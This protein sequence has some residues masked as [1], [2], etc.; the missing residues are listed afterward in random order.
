[1]ALKEDPSPSS[2]LFNS[3]PSSRQ[4]YS[5]IDFESDSEFFRGTILHEG[6][7]ENLDVSPFLEHSTANSSALVAERPIVE[8]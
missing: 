4:I 7:S 3:A 8:S 5:S 1:M 2:P 6:S